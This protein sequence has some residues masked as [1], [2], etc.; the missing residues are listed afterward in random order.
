MQRRV[1]FA[2]TTL[3]AI[4]LATATLAAA[5]AAS[6]S[7][8]TPLKF[9]A[10]A[11]AT[12]YTGKALDTCTAPSLA[13]MKTWST[14]S[15]YRGIGIYIGGPMRGCAQPNLTPAWVNSVTKQGWKLLPI[16]MGLQA[17]CSRFTNPA[18]LVSLP[19]AAAQGTTSAT[20]AIADLKAL[21]LQPGSA[22]Y[23]DMELYDTTDTACTQAVLTYISGFTTELHRRGYLAGFYVTTTGATA[24]SANYA[25][26]A[27]ARPD[28]LWVANWDSDPTVSTG[29]D[30]I[31]STQWTIHQRVKQYQGDFYATY[32]ATTA[33]VKGV[34]LRI[35]ADYIDGPVATLAHPHLISVK[36]TARSAPTT[37]ATAGAALKVGA[38]VKVICQTPGKKTAG[39][40]VW[41]KLSTGAYVNDHYVDT[42]SNTTYSAGLPRCYYPYQVTATEGT[43][44]RSDAGNTYETK[45][46]RR[47]GALAWV[48]CQKPATEMTGTTTVWDR[49]NN[50]YYVSDYDVATTSKTTY[51]APIPRC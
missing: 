1:A 5:P 23:D 44:E 17:P 51:T 11:S 21:G 37:S 39:T 29:F 26:T 9:P 8:D 6:A 38:T 3:A 41:D 4:G 36:T 46:L 49:L 14:A 12:L 16:Y 25:S 48:V 10:A 32:P 18:K 34:K 24:L 35:D 50:G 31:N 33:T 30:S 42:P 13:A 43:T 7:P 28:A 20:D 15:P 19:T 27:Y 2:V 45:G 22:V 47:T 40:A